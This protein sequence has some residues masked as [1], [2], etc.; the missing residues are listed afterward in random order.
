MSAENRADRRKASD[1]LCRARSNA[2]GVDVPATSG[3]TR[4]VTMYAQPRALA[5]GGIRATGASYDPASMFDC[6]VIPKYLDRVKNI[7]ASDTDS[8]P[9][10][11]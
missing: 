2:D 10:P 7:C 9:M 6:G 4:G 5:M 3:F 8:G 11:I 1:L